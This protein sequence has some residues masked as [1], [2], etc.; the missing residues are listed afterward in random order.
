M[1]DGITF[2]FDD[3]NRLAADLELA[4]KD[5]G[6][7]L[8]SAIKF[9]SVRVKR[10][11]ARKVSRRRHFRQAAAAI[12]FDVKHFKGFGAHVIESEIGYDKDKAAGQLGNL[13]EFGAPNS[14]NALAPGN[15]LVTTLHE[16][17]PDFIRGVEKAVDDA[18]RK[19]GL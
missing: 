9:T 14:P 11:A 3:L 13:V 7:F 10:G 8:D 16:E 5:I 12:D 17:E 15:E 6:P 19:A 4:S 1:A 18:M 2:D